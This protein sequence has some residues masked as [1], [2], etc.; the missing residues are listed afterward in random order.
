MGES[1][2]G[3]DIKVT[4]TLIQIFAISDYF[5]ISADPLANLSLHFDTKN[6]AVAFAVKNGEL[7]TTNVRFCVLHCTAC[8]YT[9]IVMG[10]DFL[11]NQVVS[12]IYSQ[13]QLK[14]LKF[15]LKQ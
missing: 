8:I 11:F 5:H 2:H 14:V 6:E 1:S 10:I 4:L 12:N 13:V 3:L 9:F 15:I 7:P